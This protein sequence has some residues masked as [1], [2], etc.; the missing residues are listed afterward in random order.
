MAHT[1]NFLEYFTAKWDV[2]G[3]EEGIQKIQD[4][5]IRNGHIDINMLI[6][7][8]NENGVSMALWVEHFS[9]QPGLLLQLRRHA[10]KWRKTYGGLSG[11]DFEK[12]ASTRRAQRAR[13]ERNYRSPL[14]DITG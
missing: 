1:N 6:D 14:S 4:T 3:A 12:I 10:V 2:K 9:M 5:I 13:R 7:N 8:S 11:D